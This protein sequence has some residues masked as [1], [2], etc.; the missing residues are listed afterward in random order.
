L[1]V[2]PAKELLEARIALNLFDCVEL[3]AQF[4]G[5][6]CFVD[7]ILTG[8]AG[9]SKAERSVQNAKSLAIRSAF[10]ILHSAFCVLHLNE[11]LVGLSHQL[12][13]AI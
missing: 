2:K 9:H 5:R 6:L 10:L 1:L 7:E 3:V 11:A 12:T 8:M 4:V 13:P